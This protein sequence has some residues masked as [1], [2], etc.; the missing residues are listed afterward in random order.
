MSTLAE[1]FPAGAG[2]EVNF[3]ASG[4][5]AADTPVGLNVDGTVTAIGSS[6]TVPE[7]LPAS[8]AK[9]FAGPNDGTHVQGISSSSIAFDPNTAGEFVLAWVEAG[10]LKARV[11]NL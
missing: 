3:T 8:A 4:A 5:I 10:V 6:A 7:A 9:I 11:G 1:L 2:K